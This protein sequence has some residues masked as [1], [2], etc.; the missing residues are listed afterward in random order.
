[1]S[2]N[3]NSSRLPMD[4]SAD[5]PIIHP[6]PP[7]VPVPASPGLPTANEDALV[8]AHA[9]PAANPRPKREARKQEPLPPA[10]VTWGLVAANVLVFVLMFC[11]AGP[12]VL[13]APKID[14]LLKWGANHA[15]LTGA[16]EYWRLLSCMFVHIG[17]I[18][19]AFNMWVLFS[20]GPLVER[21]FGKVR[22]AA[23]YFLSGLGASCISALWNPI[24]VSAGASGAIFGLFGGMLAFTHIYKHSELKEEMQRRQKSILILIGYNLLYGL[25]NSKVDNGAHFGGLAVGVIS[26]LVLAPNNSQSSPRALVGGGA[27]AFAI[28][29]LASLIPM[30]IS[31]NPG[32]RFNSY[33]HNIKPLLNTQD[34]L[35][36]EIKS[37]SSF[38]N[39]IP[40]KVQDSIL[41]L[42]R[43]WFRCNRA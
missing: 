5:D 31:E 37:A 22:Y 14:T 19:I 25:L 43:S 16:G 21:T 9:A 8:N 15:P 2:D 23:L 41:R 39:W 26:G 24:L 10:P 29:G 11:T 36:S 17:I 18:H 42:P 27:V 35:L 28:V 7:S 33:V 34:Q 20:F 38:A 1:M 3:P 32:V 13:D 30:R 12:E 4:T 6:P 40:L